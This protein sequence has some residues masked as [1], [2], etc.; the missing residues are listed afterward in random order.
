MSE[1]KNGALAEGEAFDEEQM[2]MC[3]VICDDHELLFMDSYLN[4]AFENADIVDA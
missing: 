1:L 3:Q 2:F 4:S